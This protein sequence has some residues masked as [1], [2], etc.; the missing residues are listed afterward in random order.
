MDNISIDRLRDSLQAL[1]YRFF[2]RGDYN[3]N[4]IAIR[5]ADTNA[6]TF[7]DLLCVAYKVDGQWQLKK[8]PITTDPGQYY[9]EHPMNVK[10]TAIMVPGQHSGGFKLGLRKGRFPAL[11]QARALP[12]W[13]DNNRDQQLDMTGKVDRGWHA[14]QV[15]HAREGGTS[16]I[17][18]KWSAG[19]Q[20][21][22]NADDHVELI[23]LCQ[24]QIPYWGD[25]YTWTLLNEGDLT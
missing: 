14:I 5:S 18:G 24:M 12:V 21:L 7:N 13:R 17:V 15:H 19:C 4:L 6:N 16:T 22:A 25:R 23:S 1:G 8:Y 11:I 2:E 9:R 10:G 20:V 3:L